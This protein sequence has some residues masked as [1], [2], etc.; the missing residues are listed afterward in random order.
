MEGLSFTNL[1]NY[2][3][4]TPGELAIQTERSSKVE[5][6]TVI[7]KIENS[8]G[9]EADKERKD[10]EK[11]DLQGRYVDDDKS[12]KVGLEKKISPVEIGLN[13]YKVRLNN[14]S[15]MVELI[16]QRN[17]NVVETIA[18]DALMKLV[19]KTRNPSGLL[20]DEQI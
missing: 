3:F 1:G 18:P 13:K 6:E 16:D 12:D 2:R 5:A 20:V 15:Y 19:S 9:T 17:G 8:Q 4:M 10:N 7:K 14:S 11:R